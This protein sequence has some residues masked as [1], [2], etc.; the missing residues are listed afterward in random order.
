MNTNERLAL[1]ERVNHA[2]EDQIKRALHFMIL[3]CTVTQTTIARAIRDA[4]ERHTPTPTVVFEEQEPK[5]DDE[6]ILA[7]SHRKSTKKEEDQ[8]S[9]SEDE[10][11]DADAPTTTSKHHRSTGRREKKSKTK[12]KGKKKA[13]DDQ[14]GGQNRPDSSRKKKK[15]HKKLKDAP[16]FQ[17]G[18]NQSNSEDSVGG[19]SKQRKPAIIDL[20]TSSD[21]ETHTTEQSASHVLNKTISNDHGSDH[22]SSND[23][24][25]DS[26]SSDVEGFSNEQQDDCLAGSVRLSQEGSR[27]K[28]TQ[29]GARHGEG[30]S[31]AQSVTVS[32]ARAWNQHGHNKIGSSGLDKKRKAVELAVEDVHRNQPA[33]S[34]TDVHLVKRPKQNYSK[35]TQVPPEGRKCEKCNKSFPIFE[36]MKHRRACKCT[37]ASVDRHHLP[38]APANDHR[39]E[40]KRI[41]KAGDPVGD[42][43]TAESRSTVQLPS[44]PLQTVPAD[45]ELSKTPP[46]FVQKPN[47]FPRGPTPVPMALARS[48]AGTKSLPSYSFRGM[49]PEASSDASTDKQPIS[50]Q[51]EPF[52]QHLLP[53]FER[54]ECIFCTR[55]FSHWDNLEGVC[56]CHPGMC[57][58]SSY[59]F[60]NQT[61]NQPY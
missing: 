22:D 30:D 52:R 58:S 16:N 17:T 48:N 14:E 34:A 47:N 54:K 46:R 28:I 25:S 44:T 2:S 1:S 42:I 35:E 57:R 27:M 49:K 29:A 33:K 9:A 11:E 56:K 51:P 31:R 60:S 5:D 15:K 7:S 13:I 61:L 39:H 59:L 40:I 55:W 23:H 12:L 53:V 10:D 21:V 8:S 41:Q 19:P 3:K 32:M 45:R 20:V 24:S 36:L 4:I 38:K 6:V 26:D 50:P 18:P 37:A 43:L